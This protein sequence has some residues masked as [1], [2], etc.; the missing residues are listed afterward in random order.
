MTSEVL[1]LLIGLRE[2]E[3]YL[4]EPPEPANGLVTEE[5]A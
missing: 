5:E 1:L 2:L 3:T 4:G